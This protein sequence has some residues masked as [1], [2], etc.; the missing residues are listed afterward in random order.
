VTLI[1]IIELSQYTDLI[2]TCP[3][4]L[5]KWCDT[6]KRVDPFL[7]YF[8]LSLL[9]FVVVVA[10]YGMIAI[11]DIPAQIADQRNGKTRRAHLGRSQ[12]LDGA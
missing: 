10:F 6:D 4:Y 9:F 12:L 5:S 11:R 7:N 3:R 8:V 2:E 1:N